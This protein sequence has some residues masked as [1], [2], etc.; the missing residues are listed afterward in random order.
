MDKLQAV[1]NKINDKLSMATC[2]AL[3]GLRLILG[4]T[5]FTAAMSHWSDM[6]ATRYYFGEILNIP[7][8]AFNAYLATFTEFAGGILLPLGLLTRYISIP[9]IFTMI[10]AIV[11]AHAGNGFVAFKNIPEGS[12]LFNSE[13]GLGSSSGVEIY[14]AGEK[15][16]DVTVYSTGGM[17]MPL[18]YIVMLLVLVARGPGNMSLDRLL[19]KKTF[20]RS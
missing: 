20:N 19:F 12:F 1:M 4:F 6:E 18:M 5:F 9:L 8:P 11:T 7:M 17:E 13:G 2:P 3:M 10:V 15:L 14:N 16:G